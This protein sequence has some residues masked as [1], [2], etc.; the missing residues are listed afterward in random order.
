MV[1]GWSAG[2]TALPPG[3][4]AADCFQWLENENDEDDE[5]DRKPCRGEKYV[6]HRC[7]VSSSSWWQYGTRKKCRVRV[8][9]KFVKHIKIDFT[10]NKNSLNENLVSTRSDMI[11]CFLSRS[12]WYMWICNSGKLIRSNDCALTLIRKHFLK[13]LYLYGVFFLFFFLSRCVFFSARELFYF[14]IFNPNGLIVAWK[15]GSTPPTVH[16]KYVSS[17]FFV[18]DYYNDF[19]GTRGISIYRTIS[20]DT[21]SLDQNRLLLL[22]PF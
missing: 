12:R 16:I 10:E 4:D 7:T 19:T 13:I 3:L 1:G 14:F 20:R 11:S 18:R 21:Q 6:V 15:N 17:R 5:Y 22:P 8:C 2:R 9:P